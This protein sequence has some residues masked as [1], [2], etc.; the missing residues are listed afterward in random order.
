MRAQ[1]ICIEVVHNLVQDIWTINVPKLDISVTGDSLDQVTQI[2]TDM[3]PGW[4]IVFRQKR[5]AVTKR[6]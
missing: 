2:V 4:V 6:R 5:R 1:S 3:L